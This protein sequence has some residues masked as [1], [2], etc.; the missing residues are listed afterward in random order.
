MNPTTTGQVDQLPERLK[1]VG[2]HRRRCETV[3]SGESGRPVRMNAIIL[4]GLTMPNRLRCVWPGSAIVTLSHIKGYAREA[5][6]P[7]WRGED[8]T[9]YGWHPHGHYQQGGVFRGKRSPRGT[10]AMR[11]FRFP[12][13]CAMR[14]FSFLVERGS[15]AACMPSRP[16]PVAPPSVNLFPQWEEGQ[17]DLL[18]RGTP[19]SGGPEVQGFPGPSRKGRDGR[20]KRRSTGQLVQLTRWMPRLPAHGSSW[21]TIAPAAVLARS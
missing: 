5:S 9:Q 21:L 19:I 13:E 14:L 10:A 15:A 12:V 8:A 18:G 16:R 17:G 1:R 6:R 3:R 4:S 2:R 7:V 11:R 20:R